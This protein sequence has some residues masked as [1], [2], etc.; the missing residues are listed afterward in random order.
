[1]G[2]STQEI[3]RTPGMALDTH[4]ASH[5]EHCGR[6]VTVDEFDNGGAI[7]VYRVIETGELHVEREM[8]PGVAA[9]KEFITGREV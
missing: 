1:M 6:V 4:S 8:V 9:M 7:R 5:P 3:E 2:T